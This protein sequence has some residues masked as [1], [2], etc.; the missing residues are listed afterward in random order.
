MGHR[1]FGGFGPIA[2]L[3]DGVRTCRPLLIVCNKNK[4]YGPE[5]CVKLRKQN[6]VSWNAGYLRSIDE[7][8]SLIPCPCTQWGWVA[9]R[10]TLKQYLTYTEHAISSFANSVSGLSLELLYAAMANAACVT[11]DLLS[12]HEK[13]N[14]CHSGGVAPSQRL[15]EI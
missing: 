7:S 4:C 15:F 9:Q 11:S 3:E 5:C 13:H 12:Q 2:R 14:I 8:C 1:R 10:S 6:V